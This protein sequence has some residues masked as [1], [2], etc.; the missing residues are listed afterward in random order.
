[1][2]WQSPKS[3]IGLPL[4]GTW[5][6]PGA[7]AS[8]IRSVSCLRLSS[9]PSRRTPIRSESGETLNSLIVNR[10]IVASSKRLQSTPRKKRKTGQRL[11][12]HSQTFGPTHE[13]L[14]L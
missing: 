13:E 10:F 12:G 3:K 11:T 1:M 2:V 7:T 5:I 6:V 14:G 4:G 9:G 8:E